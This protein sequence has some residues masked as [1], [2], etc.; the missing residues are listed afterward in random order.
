MNFLIKHTLL[1]VIVTAS[2]LMLI[3]N[4]KAS[5]TGIVYVD[6]HIDTKS[7]SN[8]QFLEQFR[9][10]EPHFTFKIDSVETHNSY[11]I[12]EISFPSEFITLLPK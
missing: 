7:F 2:F 3:P 5:D 4:L 12:T 10:K 1:L 6:D 11:T 9:L 8:P